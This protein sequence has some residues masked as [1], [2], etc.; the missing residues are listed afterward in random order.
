MSHVATPQAAS[1]ASVTSGRAEVVKSRSVDGAAEE[2]VAH[3]PADEGQLVPGRRE[4]LTEVGEQRQDGRQVGDR[5]PEQRGRGLTGG[6]E[7]QGYAGSRTSR[8]RPVGRPGPRPA[9]PTAR[10]G[11]PGTPLVTVTR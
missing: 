8:P 6:H 9:H 5:L 2:R 7:H 11:W 3:R 10:P 1:T 4:P